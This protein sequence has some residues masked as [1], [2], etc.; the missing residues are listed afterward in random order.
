MG[1]ERGEFG[2]WQVAG[3]AVP[4]YHYLIGTS[5]AEGEGGFG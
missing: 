1:R 3:L 5:P 2:N 4:P